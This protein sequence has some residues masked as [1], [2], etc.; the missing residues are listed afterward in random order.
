MGTPYIDLSGKIFGKLIVLSADSLLH[1]NRC[2]YWL[3]RCECGVEKIIN[4]KLLRTGQAQSCGCAIK[5]FE[6]TH[7]MSRTSIYIRYTSM[8]S[9]CYNSNRENFIRYGGRG[10]KV[11]SRWRGPQGFS[12][13]V[14]DMG[15][16]NKGE[17]LDRTDN[18]GDYTPKNCRWVSAKDNSRN[19]SNNNSIEYKGE[20]K[21]ISEWAEYY[22]IP[23]GTLTKRIMT[24]LWSVEK[25]LTTPVR[26]YQHES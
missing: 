13:F 12:N 20:V 9:R 3:C 18:D 22:K 15:L 26:G 16:P 7:G 8:L 10:I 24:Y 19:R 5:Y 6:P 4:G 11:C 25:A 2:K 17:T 14:A 1:T 21:S 23:Y